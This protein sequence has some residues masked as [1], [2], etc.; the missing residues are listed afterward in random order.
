MRLIISKFW[1]PKGFSGITIY[2]FIFARENFWKNN[3]IF[4]NHEKIHLRQQIETLV[5]PFFVWYGLEYLIRLLQYQ[6]RKKAYR[7][8]SF[9]REAYANEQNPHYLKERRFFSFLRY[10]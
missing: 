5:L 10:L 9:E 1:V 6:N 7:N 2:P 8:V 3:T 4:I